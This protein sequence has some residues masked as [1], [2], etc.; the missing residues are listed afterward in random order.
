[1][2]WYIVDFRFFLNSYN[3]CLLKLFVLSVYLFFFF[4]WWNFCLGLLPIFKL[5]KNFHCRVWGFFIYSIYKV[6]G[7]RSDFKVFSPC[8]YL[9]FNQRL[10]LQL[11]KFFYTMLG[12]KD[13][14][15]FG[16]GQLTQKWKKWP[17]SH[18]HAPCVQHVVTE[19]G[20]LMA[21]QE[22]VQYSPCRVMLLMLWLMMP[23]K[24]DVFPFSVFSAAEPSQVIN[25]RS[26]GGYLY[27]EIREINFNAQTWTSLY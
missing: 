15:D 25:Q 16:W 21:W 1:M 6:H 2:W 20:V 24:G 18:G 11:G 4:F 22:L 26:Q 10:Y 5:K 3:L 13:G 17:R 23:R 7:W 27:G 12:R 19:R 14:K 8:Q 9:V